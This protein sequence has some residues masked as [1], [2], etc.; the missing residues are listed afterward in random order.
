M[1]VTETVKPTDAELEILRVLW[2]HGPCT[3]RVV[4][5]R[6]S[7][8]PPRGYTT[9]LKLMQIMTDKG[10]VKRNEKERAHVYRAAQSAARVQGK[11]VR[12]LLH[13]AFNN[14]TA[15]LVMQALATKPASP[16]ELAEIRRM[17]DELEGAGS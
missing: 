10:L 15:A 16:Q 11:L 5:E 7:S 6:L 17:L 9:V 12:H 13:R 14:S 1:P 8:D 2:D 3:V 4:F